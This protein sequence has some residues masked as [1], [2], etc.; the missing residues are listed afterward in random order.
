MIKN[1]AINKSQAVRDY[2][3]VHPGAGTRE[4]AAAL[5]KQ[6]IKIT[7]GYV[8]TIKT[9]LYKT[10]ASAVVEKPTDTLTP[11]QIK[12]VAQAIKRIRSRLH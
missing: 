2:L 7:S 4:I 9:V 11:E 12:I 10:A 8:A 1:Q 5:K 6:G 3:K